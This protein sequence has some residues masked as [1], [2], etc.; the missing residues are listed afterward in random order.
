ASVVPSLLGV[1]EP[2]DLAGVGSL[3]VGA[4]AIEPKSAG[5]WA[6][7]RKLV[8]TYGPTEATVITAIGRVDPER[9]G[10]V[11]FGSP[12]ANTR[13]YV[14]DPS[15]GPVAQG[16]VGELY[17]A[18][19][20]LAR[21]YLGRAALTAE[22]FVADPYGPAGSRLYRTGDLAR[23]TAD[24]QLIFAGRADEQ[25]KLR[26]FRIEL[27]EVQAATAAHPDVAQAALVVR[28]DAP[29]DK[30]LVAYVVPAG[31]GEG[32]G[33]TGLGTDVRQFVAQR[34]P[35]HM[36]PA[37]VVV[38]D[39]LPL[40]VNGK[41]DRKKLPAPDY[42]SGKAG[43]GRRP[44]TPQEEILCTVF[45]EVLGVPEVGVDD[46]FFELGGHSLLGVRLV[47]QI[48][49]VLGVEVEIRALFDAP[50]VAGLAQQLGK[51]KSARP[52]LRPMRNQGDF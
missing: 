19:A 34:L 37:A 38:L 18:G 12:I 48:R 3:V 13:M 50:T 16:V 17:V 31:G 40:T 4:E 33:E 7:G 46:D 30:R 21:G 23:W 26:G 42:A 43:G 11:P 24:G 22:R 20:G 28:E 36:V 14:L 10:T 5:V 52:A 45:A 32:A 41:L 6:R 49:A 27:G 15:L 2:G 8:N 35:A 47:S 1:L 29:G 9:E 39:S 25:V 51:Q 44:S